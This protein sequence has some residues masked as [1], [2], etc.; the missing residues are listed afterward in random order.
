M[1]RRRSLTTLVAHHRLRRPT[2]TTLLAPP[3]ATPV[4]FTNTPSPP[5]WLTRWKLTL[6]SARSRSKRQAQRLRSPPSAV[7]TPPPP[8]KTVMDR[9][10]TD[11]DSHNRQLRP[12]RP[13]RRDLR[14]AL[15]SPCAALHLHHPQVQGLRN[16]H[17]Y[18]HPHRLPQ[19]EQP[20]KTSPRGSPSTERWCSGRCRKGRKG[21]R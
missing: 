16:R 14:L 2:A 11:R 5:T 15:H 17:P 19:R 6:L 21:N 7:R 9:L 4:P 8:S 13:G 3:T 1:P 18:S 12:S 20:S 10:L